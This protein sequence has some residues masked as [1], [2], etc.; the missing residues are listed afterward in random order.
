[1]TVNR[2]AIA[3]IS[4]K[5]REIHRDQHEAECKQRKAELHDKELFEQP[6]GT[7]DG[8]CPLC[9]LPLPIDLEKSTFKSCC[10]K[11]MR[12]GCDYANYLS[13]GKDNC[14]FCAFC[15]ESRR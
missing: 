1:M 2:L 14:P 3:A 4:A 11:M 9:F 15:V 6:D 5:C 10:C 7:H 8:E 13:S 12:L